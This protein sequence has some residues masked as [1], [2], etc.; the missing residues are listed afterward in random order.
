MTSIEWAQK[1]WNPILGCDKISAGCKNCYA[2][3]QAYRNWEM[4]KEKVNKGRIAY[5]EGL[6]EKRGDRRPEWTGKVNF[7]PEA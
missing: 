1:T 3:N 2:I 5:Y 6:T 7:V 4:G